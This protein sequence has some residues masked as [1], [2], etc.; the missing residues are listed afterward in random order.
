VGYSYE[1]IRAKTL[2]AKHTR[3]VDS[4]VRLTKPSETAISTR[5][6]TETVEYEPHIPTLGIQPHFLIGFNPDAA[7]TRNCCLI[8]SKTL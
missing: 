4:G 6:V 1:I 3:K 7:A 5:S 2:Y 8:V